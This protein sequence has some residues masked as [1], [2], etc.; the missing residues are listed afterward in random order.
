MSNKKETITLTIQVK[1]WKVG[2]GHSEHRSGAGVHGD[3]RTKRQR[4]RSEQNRNAIKE[5]M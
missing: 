2:R 3:R 1:P 4:T 5:S